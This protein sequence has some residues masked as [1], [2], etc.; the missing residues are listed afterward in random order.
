MNNQDK[1]TRK[2]AK[3]PPKKRRIPEP[4]Q[5]VVGTDANGDPVFGRDP[6]TITGP[7][8]GTS[9]ANRSDHLSGSPYRS[10]RGKR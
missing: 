7:R 5:I 4:D 8:A 1:Y 3:P 10:T 6:K 2:F 9:S